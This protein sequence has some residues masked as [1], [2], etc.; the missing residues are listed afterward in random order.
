MLTFHELETRF[1]PVLALE[2]LAEIEKS[3]AI[4]PA[5]MAGIDPELRLR[6]AFTIQDAAPGAARVA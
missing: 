5:R 4:A 6:A 1:G 2:Y 3:A